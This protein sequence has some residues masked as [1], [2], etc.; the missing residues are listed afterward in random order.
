MLTTLI[1][2]LLQLVWNGIR[3]IR[4][5]R[6]RAKASAIEG[7]IIGSVCLGA[8]I[9]SPFAV[10]FGDGPEPTEL[11]L[12][13]EERR[14]H[15][16]Q[17]GLT[18]TGKTNLAL[19]LFRADVEQGRGLCLVDYRGELVDRALIILA[20]M[21]SPQ[22]LRGRLLLIDLRDD[23]Y[24]VPFNPLREEAADPY[25]RVRFAMDLLK[26]QWDL[27]V[28][29]EQTLRNSL[30]ALT[31][32]WSFNELEILLTNQAFRNQVLKSVTDQTVLRF[33]RRFEQLPNTSVLVEPVINKVSP[34]LARPVLRNML[35]ATNTI[36][37]KDFIARRPDCILLISLAADTLHSDADM[38]G[39]LLTSCIM[40]AAM[41]PE[42]RDVPGNE[43]SLYLDECEHF[44]GLHEQ[45]TQILS[46]GRKFGLCAFLSHQT[47]IQLNPQLRNLI[48]NVVGTQI[49]FG[50]GGG[51]GDTLAGE[52]ASDEPKAIM[53][54]LLLRQKNGE[55]IVL[56]RGQPYTRIRTKLVPDPKVADAKVQALRDMALREFG[57]PRAQVEAEL[58]ARERSFNQMTMG[59]TASIQQTRNPRRKPDAASSEASL[60]D[61]V[62]EVREHD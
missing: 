36:S 9:R 33:F 41:R 43:I 26:Q 25:S 57:K 21:F 53:R 37:F 45:L 35:S 46:E 54:N 7:N 5:P 47:T 60:H 14:R 30:L 59:D 12:T 31:G 40:S 48:R 6:R 61:A 49:Y 13:S 28:T 27:G 11:I 50:V 51:E 2:L 24:G 18:G 8:I 19:Q 39:S 15:I 44:D 20:S 22:E 3:G 62:L 34:F 52:I 32:S 16:Y 58:D 38:M 55:A 1:E 10:P 29:V 23:R 42:R 17:I 4:R 56:R